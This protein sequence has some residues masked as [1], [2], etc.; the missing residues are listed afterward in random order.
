MQA[1][2]RMDETRGPH[3]ILL[4]QND[5]GCEGRLPLLCADMHLR[6]GFY[7]RVFVLLLLGQAVELRECIVVHAKFG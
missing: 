5:S 2:R 1:E 3:R 6:A 7:D 4:A